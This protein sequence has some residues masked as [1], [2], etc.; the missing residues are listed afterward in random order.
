MRLLCFTSFTVCFVAQ[1]KH[2]ARA[3]HK[4]RRLPQT[5]HDF[6]PAAGAGAG[7]AA[8]VVSASIAQELQRVEVEATRESKAVLAKMAL[9]SGAKVRKTNSHSTSWWV[10]CK[11]NSNLCVCGPMCTLCAQL[12]IGE[13][14][15]NSG[16]WFEDRARWI[17][18]RL[19]DVERRLLRLVEVRFHLALDRGSG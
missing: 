16:Y 11:G 13:R 8:K 12:D 19:N 9:V 2:G 18:I 4:S 14:N 3:K 10:V 7:A 5:Q 1:H 15:E 6:K 17:P